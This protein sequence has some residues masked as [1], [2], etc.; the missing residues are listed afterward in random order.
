MLN[1][2]TLERLRKMRLDGMADAFAQQMQATTHDSLSF[3]ERFGMMVDAE[4]T[5][6]DGRRLRRLLK[7]AKLR[8]AACVEDIDWRQPRSLD[9]GVILE[10][11]GCDWIRSRHNVLIEGPTGAGKTYLACALANAACRQGFS[12]R[13]YR[14]PRLMTELSVAKGDGSYPRLL[15]K[16]S[17]TQLL[18]LDDWGLAPFTAAES[19]DIL[20][21]IEDRSQSS[22]TIV[23]SQLPCE[24]WHSAIADPSVA[25]AVLDRLIHNAHRLVMKGES[26]R[27]LKLKDSE[28]SKKEQN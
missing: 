2:H 9:R 8:V 16:L 21:V 7:E 28:P 1:Q 19:R 27:K 14:V 23:A 11:A 18:V 12:A 22:S 15:A 25:D 5:L 26:M 24:H 4:W 20:E 3:G 10:L 17:R 6:R 13:Y